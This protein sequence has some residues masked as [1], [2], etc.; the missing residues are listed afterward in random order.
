[1]SS[2]ASNPAS[3]TATA[4][5][6]S[7]IRSVDGVRILATGGFVPDNVVRNE[8]LA[9]L[10]C[11]SDWIIQRTGIRE[12]RH[13]PPNMATSDMAVE[14]AKRCIEQID[15]N[16]DEVD[17]LIVATMT[18]DTPVPSTACVV[19]EQLGIRAPAFDMNAACAGFMYAMATGMQYVSSGCSQLALIIGADTNSRIVNPA[20]KKTFPLFGDGAGAVLLGSRLDKTSTTTYTLGADGSGKDLLRI[21]AGGSRLPMT[22]EL[23]A[24]DK[25]YME[26]DGRSVF[27]WAVRLLADT[28]RDV[29]ESAELT[30]DDLDLIVLHQANQRIIDAAADDLG[31]PKEKLEINLDRYG[32]TSAASIPLGLN[33]AARS[34]R[35]KA[36]DRVLL[37]GFGAGLAWGTAVL[38]W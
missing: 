14:A 1:M 16:P 8:D 32:N 18:P 4:S 38:E 36:G 23:L 29:L 5:S 24:D 13:A 15:A 33:D 6:T 30:V 9:K 7:R 10:G 3:Q 22:A 20:N 11:D 31:I 21:P 19:Q 37:C 35:L 17:L 28:V 25:Q 2:T 26:M 34:G 12:R 27:K